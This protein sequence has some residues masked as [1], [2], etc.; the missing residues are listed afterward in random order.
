MKKNCGWE[1]MTSMGGEEKCIHYFGGRRE[2][3]TNVED[4]IKMNLK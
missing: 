4:K 1:H 3:Q 2:N